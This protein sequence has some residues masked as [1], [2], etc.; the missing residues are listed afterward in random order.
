MALIDDVKSVCS[1]LAG[2][3]WRDL[4]LQFGLDIKASNLK[5]ELNK[6]LPKL[7]PGNRPRV[8]GFEDFSLKGSR[9]I[10]PGVPDRSL[11]FH[12]FASPQV[13]RSVDGSMRSE[14]HTSELQ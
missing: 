9:G 10:E 1:G 5:I 3:G 8:P 4:L 13:V 7:S 12:A 14:E 2:S 6:A 11:L